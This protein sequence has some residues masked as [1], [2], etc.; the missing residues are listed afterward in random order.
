M[1]IFQR[2]ADVVAAN[3]NDFVDRFEEPEKMLRHALR[4]MEVLLATTS[5]AVARS[6]AA[7]KLLAKSQAEHAAEAEAWRRRAAA[8][9][10]EGDDPLARRAIERKLA[11]QRAASAALAQLVGARQTNETLRRQLETLREKHAAA[12]SRLT[13]LTAR[14]TAAE[15]Q[16]QALSTSAAPLGRARA[17]ARFD[18]FCQQVEFAEAE[19]AALVELETHGDAELESMF[20]H[21]DIETAID[22]ELARLKESRQAADR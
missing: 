14:Q 15:A 12:G 6:I 18:R 11:H 22:A 20:D 2:A 4:E 1:G 13:T 10:D 3:L 17:L 21:R 8:A 9:V 7:E 19:A 16:R 5:L